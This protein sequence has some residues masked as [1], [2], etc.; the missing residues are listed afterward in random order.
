MAT[1]IASGDLGG[2]V[3]TVGNDEPALLMQALVTISSRYAP[4]PVSPETWLYQ[5]T[6]PGLVEETIFRGVLQTA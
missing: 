1:R 3:D 5:T 4:A 2:R 6:L